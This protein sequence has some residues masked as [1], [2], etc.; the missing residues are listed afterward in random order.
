[1]QTASTY[2]TMLQRENAALRAQVHD[3]T[4]LLAAFDLSELHD[5]HLEAVRDRVFRREIAPDRELLQVYHVER[6]LQQQA[7]YEALGGGATEKIS[8][9]SDN[10]KSREVPGQLETSSSV[11]V[12]VKALQ[13]RVKVLEREVVGLQLHHELLSETTTWSSWSTVDSDDDQTAQVEDAESSSHPTRSAMLELDAH[14][15]AEVDRLV[16]QEEQASFGEECEDATGTIREQ[17]QQIVELE[18]ALA[19]ESAKNAE[20]QQLSR[21]FHQMAR[22]LSTM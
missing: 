14:H 2:D 8:N 22:K 10:G 16:E 18:N 17:Q 5:V 21:R 9:V 13:Q 19:T 15:R 11:E 20:L 3:L 1:M 12:D 6:Q 4:E 7:L